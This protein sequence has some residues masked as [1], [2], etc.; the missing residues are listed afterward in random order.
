MTDAEI[1]VLQRDVERLEDRV[2]VIPRLEAQAEAMGRE[3][4]QLRRDMDAG[5]SRVEKAVDE[6]ASDGK[7]NR[8]TL[9][10]FALTI[11]GSA[12][13]VVIALASTGAAG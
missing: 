9:I 8:W 4:G 3:I 12:V 2:A 5:F 7:R 13:S 1:Q 10:G 6:L 11:A